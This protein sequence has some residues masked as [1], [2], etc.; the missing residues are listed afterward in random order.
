MKLIRHGDVTLRPV[1]IPA[2]AK[3]QKKGKDM[4]IA[5]GEGTG[6]HHTL[7]GSIPNAVIMKGFNDRRFV[8]VQEDLVLRHQEHKELPVAKGT[9]EIIIEQERN[10]FLDD[11]RKVID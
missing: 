11:I 1:A 10:P 5:L 4:T 8:E 6:H 2:E 9:Y 3:E 7:Y